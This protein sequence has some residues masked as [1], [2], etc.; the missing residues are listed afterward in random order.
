MP[1]NS[2]QQSASQDETFAIGA[3]GFGLYDAKVANSDA[4]PGLDGKL[5]PYGALCLG[6]SRLIARARSH[7]RH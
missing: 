4:V 7:Q 2:R 6:A 5:L 1:N 3:L